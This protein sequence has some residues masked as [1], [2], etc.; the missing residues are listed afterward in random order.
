[1]DVI[2]QEIVDEFKNRM[3][4]DGEEDSNLKFILE[5]SYEDLRRICGQYG[6]ED[7]R[8]KELVYERS[9]YVYNDA[10]EYFHTNFLTQINNLSLDKA[11]E[12]ISVDGETDATI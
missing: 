2:T 6:L 9:R 11:L 5:A 7:R 8:F 4:L 1:M 10:L 3:H 12:S